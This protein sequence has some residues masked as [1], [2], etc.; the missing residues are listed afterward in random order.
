L[1]SGDLTLDIQDNGKT[2]FQTTD[3][4][5][6]TLPVTATPIF[7][8]IVNAGAFGTVLLSVSPQAA[9]KVQGP[10]L[11]GTNDKD[12]LN[13]KA[14]ARRG[15]YIRISNAGDANGAVVLEQ[16]GTWATE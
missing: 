7:C 3:A 11:A 10:D 14:T 5:T 16:V 8:T 15:D 12:H 4:K 13:T 2:F 6:V 9:D 1:A